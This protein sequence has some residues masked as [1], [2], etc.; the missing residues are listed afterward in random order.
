MRS[1]RIRSESPRAPDAAATI[2]LRVRA[3]AGDR[4]HG[5]RPPR[6]RSQARGARLSRVPPV[7]NQRADGDHKRAGN[8]HDVAEPTAIAPAA[9]VNRQVGRV[10]TV[11]LVS[12]HTSSF[13][14]KAGAILIACANSS[15]RWHELFMCVSRCVRKLGVASAFTTHLTVDLPCHACSLELASRCRRL[16]LCRTWHVPVF[17]FAGWADANLGLAGVPLLA[18]PQAL[19]PLPDTNCGHHARQYTL[20]YR[21]CKRYFRERYTTESCYSWMAQRTLRSFSR[22]II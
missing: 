20:T 15:D 19:E 2:R 4:A 22:V 5:R 7:G 12:H 14:A 3:C 11:G 9:F 18:T 17:C 8:Q 13:S 10:V 1:Q 21:R 16:S 6:R